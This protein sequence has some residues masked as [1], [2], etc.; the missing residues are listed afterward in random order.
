MLAPWL[1][2][3]I[4]VQ[5]RTQNSRNS[6]NEPDY[7]PEANY[8]TIYTSVWARIEY[9]SK[10]MAFT[11]TGERVTLGGNTIVMTEPDVK[12]QPEDRITILTTDDPEQLNKTYIV[13][14]NYSEWDSMGNVH[15]Y[16]STI[17]V[18]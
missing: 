11:D 17:E 4:K 5:R 6:L 12:L 3:Q 7:G 15:H 18:H 16:V 13:M 9:N 2:L 8:P 10:S 1:N 14:E